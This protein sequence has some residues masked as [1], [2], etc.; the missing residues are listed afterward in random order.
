[1]RVSDFHFE[2]PDELIARY[3]MPERSASRLL[4][5]DET[6][7]QP[8]HR[9]FQDILDYLNPGDL[10]VLNNTRV[11]PARLFGQKASGGKIEIL[12]ER[13][14]DEHQVLAHVRQQIPKPGTLL[15]LEG[16]LEAEMIER[17]DALFVLRF[18]GESVIRLLEQHGHM[19][20]PHIHP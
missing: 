10:L 18:A 19:P 8:I 2:L 11:I 16:G 14:L 20:L 12:V 15:L 4:V 1:M 17:R 3:P 13:V 6:S 5:V 9:T 7:G